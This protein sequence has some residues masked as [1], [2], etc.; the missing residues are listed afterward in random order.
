[1]LVDGTLVLARHLVNGI[2]IT[3]PRVTEE[4]HYFNIEFETH[5]CLLAE[6]SWSESFSDGPGLR[7]AFHNAADF[8]ARFPD[9]AVPEEVA[10]C[11]PR[12]VR[13]PALAQALAPV[14]TRAAIIPGA[15]RGWVDTIGA[16]GRISGWAQ[17]SANPEYPITLDIFASETHLGSTLACEH[18]GDLAEA[19][20]GSGRCAFE[21]TSPDGLTET[22]RRSIR[23]VPRTSQVALP[24]TEA[25]MASLGLSDASIRLS[26]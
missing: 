22:M 3:Q 24:P 2:S 20:L 17:D 21:F 6:G 16:D 5:D 8:Y 13:G 4:I 19:G 14:L 26:A 12:P 15:M 9:Q 11:A 10:L 23:V 1:M 25:C 18:R 7:N